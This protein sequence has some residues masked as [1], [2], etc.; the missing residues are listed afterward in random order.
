MIRNDTGNMDLQEVR[1]KDRNGKYVNIIYCV[2]ST[3]T[4]IHMTDDAKYIMYVDAIHIQIHY[5]LYMK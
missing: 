4:N 1:E 2:F 3:L 5:S